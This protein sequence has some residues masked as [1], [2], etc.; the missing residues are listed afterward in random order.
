MK[1]LADWLRA[2]TLG[3]LAAAAASLLGCSGGTV[4]AKGTNTPPAVPVSVFTA[5]K[6]DVPV[7][8][9]GLGNVTAFNTVNV[10]SRVDGAITQV[11]F[12]E[13]Q[14]VKQGDLLIQIDPRPYQVQ[15]E[16]AEGQLAKDQAQLKD[17]NIDLARDTELVASGVLAQQQLDLQRAQAGQLEGT[18]KSDQAQIDN[19]KLQL[20]Y[21]RITAPISG[22]VGLR[23]VDIGNI[24]HASD[25]N[26]LVVI[27]QLQPISVVFTLPEDNLQT[28]SKHMQSGELEVD[29]YS[30]DD[31]T[32]LATGKLQS[33]DNQIDQ[34]TG[35]GRLKA[36]FDNQDNSLWPNQFVNARLQLE[37]RKD[38]T[39]I[40]SAAIQR[41]PNGTYVYVVKP[42]KSVDIRSVMV[43]LNQSNLS[44]IESGLTPGEVVVTDGQ[45]KLQS[46]SRVEPRTGAAGGGNS[47]GGGRRGG[48]SQQNGSNKAEAGGQ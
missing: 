37:V 14:Q 6:R 28:V 23:L 10:K 12:K 11:N 18:I 34:T 41:G 30:R 43:A 26:P 35:T 1:T 25:S 46:G 13:G 5:E 19:A 39:V 7:Y 20:T 15:L 29:A 16:Q 31:Q 3:V 47:N 8:L 42:D 33:L 17:A 38:S 32:K 9:S 24:V 2:A 21:S 22:R 27:T 40:P 48:Q 44:V 36:I 4:R 45:D